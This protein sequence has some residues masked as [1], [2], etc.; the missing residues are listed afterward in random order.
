M[1]FP[2]CGMHLDLYFWPNSVSLTF[3]MFMMYNKVSSQPIRLCIMVITLLSMTNTM[4]T[5]IGED[6]HNNVNKLMGIADECLHQFEDYSRN[7]F[8]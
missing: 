2:S 7:L 6:I 1:E 8:L 4:I 3:S 5:K